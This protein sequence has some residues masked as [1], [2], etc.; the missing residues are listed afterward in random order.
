MKWWEAYI[1]T[2]VVILAICALIIGWAIPV[3]FTGFLSQINYLAREYTW[4][5][6]LGTRSFQ[7]LNACPTADC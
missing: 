1:R 3:T 6:W 2:G 5:H 4:L 7:M